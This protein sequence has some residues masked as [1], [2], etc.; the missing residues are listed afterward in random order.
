MIHILYRHTQHASGAGK[1]RPEG[2]TYDK[3]LNN[4]LNTIE[5]NDDITF[6][7]IYDGNCTITDDRIHKVVEFT[8][9]SDKASFFY[10]WE[11]AKELNLEDKD[12]VYFLEND[13]LH[14]PGWYEKVI[15]LYNSFNVPG[16]V[17]LYDHM[18]K[19]T[20]EMYEDLQSQLYVTKSSHWR[21]VP[22]TCGSFIINKQILKEDY[23]VHTSMYSDHDKFLMLGK[24]RN[25]IIISSIPGL[26]THCESQFMTPVIDWSVY[27]KNDKLC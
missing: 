4:I 3:C 20:L 22:S 16:Y 26:S 15:D 14:L 1:Q 27:L 2:F 12:L 11:Y 25:R 5:G 19:Y 24:T 8:G 6:H 10:T 9:G 17:A 21:T 18:D 23:D 7:L 13:Y